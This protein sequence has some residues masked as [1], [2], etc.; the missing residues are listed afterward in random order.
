MPAV[1]E[2]IKNGISAKEITETFDL[3]SFETLEE[4]TKAYQSKVETDITNLM[5]F[6]GLIARMHAYINHEDN[7][8][9]FPG[10][11]TVIAAGY[12]SRFFAAEKEDFFS[13]NFSLSNA[14]LAEKQLQR[15]RGT[16]SGQQRRSTALC[17][18]VFSE[19]ASICLLYA[20]T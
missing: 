15:R 11:R 9:F 19:S 14:Y 6:V 20:A 7:A 12:R 2:S 16:V 17:K 13:A 3:D 10:A 18:P 1:G 4:F 5:K 8:L